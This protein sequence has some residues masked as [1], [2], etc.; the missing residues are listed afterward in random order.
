MVQDNNFGTWNIVGTNTY[1]TAYP[2]HALPFTLAGE[3]AGLQY[4]TAA[5]IYRSQLSAWGQQ[6]AS[7]ADAASRA[8]AADRSYDAAI[9]DANARLQGINAQIRADYLRA[10]AGDIAAG[11]RLQA[12]LQLQSQIENNRNR[13]EVAKLAGSGGL[14]DAI[15]A[16]YAAYGMGDIPALGGSFLAGNMQ[17]IT[18]PTVQQMQLGQGMNLIPQTQAI[19]GTAGS[20]GGGFGGGGGGSMPSFQMPNFNDIFNSTYRNIYSLGTPAIVPTR[21]TGGTVSPQANSAMSQEFTPA[22][23][24]QWGHPVA[25]YAEGGMP[26]RAP[27]SARIVG[28][29]G[30]EVEVETPF[31]LVI[32]PLQGQ[33]QDGGMLP[34]GFTGGYSFGQPRPSQ[35][36]IRNAQR[37]GASPTP[38]TQ[39]ETQDRSWLFNQQQQRAAQGTSGMGWQRPP[40]V[41]NNPG[42]NAGLNAPPA[43]PAPPA[44]PAT[45]TPPAAAYGGNPISYDAATSAIRAAFQNTGVTGVMN[46]VQDLVA[47]GYD[48]NILRQYVN[49]IQGGFAE[50]GVV[51]NANRVA[52]IYRAVSGLRDALYPGVR[53]RSGLSTVSRPAQAAPPAPVYTAANPNPQGVLSDINNMPALQM[54][55]GT[56]PIRSIYQLPVL[57]RPELGIGEIPNPFAV[58]ARYRQM[59]PLAQRD[60][61]ETMQSLFGFRPEQTQNMINMATPGY[62]SQPRAA[63][64]Y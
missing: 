54:A 41:W 56:A 7:A 21:T 30:P 33:F 48:I 64:G 47:Q 60:Y 55:R 12:E 20:G 49:E 38:A 2:Y 14:M 19:R 59:D 3:L 53:R 58:A 31:G 22:Q 4:G 6:Q 63:L 50:G 26:S 46:I 44:P 24:T 1:D 61:V 16:R 28:E 32:A 27:Y 23:Y 62:R 42:R 25:G 36:V 45:P 5:D 9:A 10:Q 11:N 40:S 15:S 17:S 29:K 34:P 52:N 35:R 13:L 37:M 18:A 8:Y 51:P 39:P 43:T 57:A